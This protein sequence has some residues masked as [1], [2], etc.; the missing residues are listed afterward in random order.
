M[1][2]LN[3]QFLRELE[4]HNRSTGKNREIKRAHVKIRGILQTAKQVIE[5]EASSFLT[6]QRHLPKMSYKRAKF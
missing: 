3:G 4:D 2:L 6:A 5:K 1:E